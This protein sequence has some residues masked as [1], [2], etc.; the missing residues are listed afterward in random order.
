MCLPSQGFALHRGVA[1]RAL[2]ASLRTEILGLLR[3][4]S[5]S[6]WYHVGRFGFTED[7]RAIRSPWR[8]H[9]IPLQLTQNVGTV[10][11]C[12]AGFLV[13][14]GVLPSARLVELSAAITLPGASSQDTH[15]D[16]SAGTASVGEA[17][18][19]PLVTCWVALHPIL[20]PQMGPTVVYPGTHLRYA[21]RSKRL[22]REAAE[23]RR[24]KA[25][26]LSSLELDLAL[27]ECDD[28]Q[29]KRIRLQAE[30]VKEDEARE[31]MEFG[32]LKDPIPVL[33][34]CGDLNVMDCRLAHFGSSYPWQPWS[35]TN[36]QPRTLLNATFANHDDEE[37]EGFTYH[38]HNA[39]PKFTL[40]DCCALDLSKN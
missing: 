26:L 40:K 23:D 5:W 2:C 25:A 39:F 24:M 27:Q 28:H 16:I 12:L 8:R 10:L 36:L 17:S 13:G 3:K 14:K 9:V 4:Q 21:S 33:L 15:T 31:L 38:I 22:A 30:A 11:K 19:P 7:A 32:P 34:D 6:L 20:A 37:E 35:L 29:A 18:L 1:P